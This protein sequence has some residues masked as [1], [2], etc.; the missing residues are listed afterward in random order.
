MTQT[1]KASKDAESGAASDPKEKQIIIESDSESASSTRDIPS[2]NPLADM[3]SETRN[4]IMEYTMKKARQLLQQE[5]PETA[6]V[7][8]RHHTTATDNNNDSDNDEFY[9]MEPYNSDDEVPKKHLM[10]I[11]KKPSQR[12][13]YHKNIKWVREVLHDM[14]KLNTKNWYAWNPK[15]IDAIEVWPEAMKHLNGTYKTGSIK[16]DYKLDRMLSIIMQGACQQSGPDNINFAISRPKGSPSW[17]LHQFYH[18]LE[19]LLTKADNI[20]SAELLRQVDNIH[21]L[22]GDVRK[23]VATIRNHW[24]RAQQIRHPLWRNS[25][26]RR[27][28][29]KLESATHTPNA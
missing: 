13:D 5:E 1:R 24:A 26:S 2:D 4:Q 19:D 29:R 27:S 18:H 20:T 23:L 25:R 11:F 7:T 21:M 8:D 3:S 6:T 10:D 15:F 17:S 9:D 28:S 12:A 16:F 14:P 22:N